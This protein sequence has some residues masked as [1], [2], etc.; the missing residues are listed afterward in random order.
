MQTSMTIVG[1]DTLE[2]AARAHPDAAESIEAWTGTVARAEWRSL[3][4]V[5]K[6]YPHADGVRL[7]SGVVVTVFNVGGNKYRL[8]TTISYRAQTV[9]VEMFL[10][11][12]E[13]DK[14]K[15]KRQL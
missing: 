3:L 13:Y 2:D 9:A 5:R 12:A 15:W 1:R 14:E 11:H 6:T 4:D 10:T 7:R 8:L